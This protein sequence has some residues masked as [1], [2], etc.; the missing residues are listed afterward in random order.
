MNNQM[1]HQGGGKVGRQGREGWPCEMCFPLNIQEQTLSTFV[2]F[3]IAVWM[4]HIRPDGC[5]TPET[6]PNNAT[7]NTVNRLATRPQGGF[8]QRFRAQG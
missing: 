7:D 5:I 1:W 8:S 6:L 4:T 3:K 2:L